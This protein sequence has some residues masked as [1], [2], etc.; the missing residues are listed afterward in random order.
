MATC[1]G[2]WRSNVY[3]EATSPHAR[4]APYVQAV[5]TTDFAS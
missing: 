4:W 2:H 3:I 5:E 1:L